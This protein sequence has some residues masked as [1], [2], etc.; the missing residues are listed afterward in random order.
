MGQLVH[1]VNTI[2]NLQDD[3]QVVFIPCKCQIIHVLP[4]VQLLGKL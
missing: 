1:K 4:K 3:V 2:I